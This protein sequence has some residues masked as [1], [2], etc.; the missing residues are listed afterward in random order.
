[1]RHEQF[2]GVGVAVQRID[3]R[4]QLLRRIKGQMPR[5]P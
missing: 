1:M 2:Q 3:D 5:S 4:I